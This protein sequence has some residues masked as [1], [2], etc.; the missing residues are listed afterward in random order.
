V[1]DCAVMMAETHT[2]YRACLARLT[3]QEL[4]RVVHYKNSAGL[5][6]D[7][8]VE[9]IL[10]QVA[11]HAMNHRGQVSAQLR[12]AGLEPNGTDYIGFVR[13]VPA[14]TRTGK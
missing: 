2:A 12:A 1:D 10:L 11:L 14:A 13:G 9:D 4:A 3:E 8:T 5:E 7:S 6:F